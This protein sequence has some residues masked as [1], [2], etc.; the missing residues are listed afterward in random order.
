MSEQVK[1]MFSEVAGNYDKMN[2]L[3][4]FNMHNSWKRKLVRL[5]GAKKGDHVLDC[6]SGTGD[7]AFE[8]K[9]VVGDNGRVLATDFC[10]GMLNYVQPKG[11][12]LGLS[13][14]V[15]L[16]DA[17]N[18]QYPDNTFDIVSISYGIRNV[19]DTSVAL[20]EMA[21]V[22]KPGGKIAILE[23]GQPPKILL[24]LYYL[25][26]KLLLP[27]LSRLITGNTSAY[28]YLADTASSYPYGKKFI[29][30]M[31]QTQAFTDCQS[32]SMFLGA[33]FIYLGTAK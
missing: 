17:M 33:S 32:K 16:A 2:D 20:K 29:Q 14:E 12:K 24:P 15:E 18:L 6:A 8:F 21:R 28:K 9:K 27:L 7:L 30:L 19:D 26:T 23:T 4:T 5:A 10:E 25:V 22:L 1:A 31:E 13:V 11:K 3:F